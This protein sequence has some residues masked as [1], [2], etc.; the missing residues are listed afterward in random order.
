MRVFVGDS[1]QWIWTTNENIV[2]SD[3]DGLV[4]LSPSLRE[5][6]SGKLQPGGQ[7]TH[8][9]NSEGK[10]YYTSENSQSL[11]GYVTVTPQPSIQ[12]DADS[13]RGPVTIPEGIQFDLTTKSISEMDGCWV[14]C[15]TRSIGDGTLTD[16]VINSNCEGE[17]ILFGAGTNPNTLSIAA[18][19]KQTVF[20][21]AKTK[22]PSNS[23]NVVITPLLENG[24]YWYE[25][26]DSMYSQRRTFGFSSSQSINLNYNND[27]LTECQHS[28]TWAN[29]EKSLSIGTGFSC[30]VC[31][32][33]QQGNFQGAYEAI[34]TNTCSIVAP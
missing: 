12:Y 24:V 19:A 17:W 32:V 21:R 4:I 16:D 1:V 28:S 31:N 33:F 30:F 20:I 9:F 14:Q 2:S 5:V 11:S 15:Y 8:T 27:Y 26:D 13:R 3:A 7:W 18:F 25:Y 34:Y 29:C 10:F 22:G 23:Q 6:Y